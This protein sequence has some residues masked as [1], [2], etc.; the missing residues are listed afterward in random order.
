MPDE[1]IKIEK[2]IPIPAR[3]GSEAH[4]PWENME[5][6]DSFLVPGKGKT[7]KSLYVMVTKANKRYSPRRFISRAVKG[8]TRVWR[9]QDRSFRSGIE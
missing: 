8:G 3:G 4:Y 1:K 5:V 2:G 6:G 7:S 9:I